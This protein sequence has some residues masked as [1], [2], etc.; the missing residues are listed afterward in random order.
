[1]LFTLINNK[2]NPWRV[3]KSL[4][5]L[6]SQ[7]LRHNIITV[8]C[9]YIHYQWL[10]FDNDN[11][12]RHA[13]LSLATQKFGI[14]YDDICLNSY[15]QLFYHKNGVFPILKTSLSHSTAA[16]LAPGTV[17]TTVGT[18]WAFQKR[19]FRTRIQ[20]LPLR[21]RFLF[22]FSFLFSI[23]FVLVLVPV[24][25]LVLVSSFSRLYLLL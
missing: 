5:S 12:Q 16:K 20:S 14:V 17:F 7:F 10:Q 22:S 23:V 18:M 1:M 6:W 21:F 9:N 4:S 15:S 25:V 3:A 24:L 8:T 2:L 13:S 11:N 19:K